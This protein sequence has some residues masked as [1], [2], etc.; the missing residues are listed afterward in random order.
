MYLILI[1][2]NDKISRHYNYDKTRLPTPGDDTDA[3][4]GEH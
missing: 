1:L 2:L 3:S 4:G